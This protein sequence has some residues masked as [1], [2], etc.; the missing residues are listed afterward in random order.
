M[1]PYHSWYT[2]NSVATIHWLLVFRL[3]LEIAQELL[4]SSG[5]HLRYSSFRPVSR[6][7]QYFIK[8]QIQEQISE[9]FQNIFSSKLY[10]VQLEEQQFNYKDRQDDKKH[11]SNPNITFMNR[12]MGTVPATDGITQRQTNASPPHQ[13]QLRNKN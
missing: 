6:N 10:L 12:G 2:V 5:Y 8:I 13:L 1:S 7:P 4:S 3:M 9:Y 11:P